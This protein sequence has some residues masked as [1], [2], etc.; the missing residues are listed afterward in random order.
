M[1]H[2]EQIRKLQL[3]S[4]CQDWNIPMP[5]ECDCVACL[6]KKP[7][8]SP[9]LLPSSRSPTSSAPSTP[10]SNNNNSNNGHRG[11]ASRWGFGGG[12]GATRKGKGKKKKKGGKR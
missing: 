5:K 8:L 6:F 1:D 9:S 3:A 12:G 7:E 2:L 4:T 10:T 11:W